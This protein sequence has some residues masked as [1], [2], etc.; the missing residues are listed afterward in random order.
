MNEF[1]VNIEE[2]TA[3]NITVA[4]LKHL[5]DQ[6]PPQERESQFQQAC[7]EIFHFIMKPQEWEE[8]YDDDFV[9]YGD[10]ERDVPVHEF[11]GAGEYKNRQAMVKVNE[12]G[13]YVEMYL[14]DKFKERRNLYKHSEQYA[15][16]CAENWVMGVI[17]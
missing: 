4:Y 16:D 2:D 6:Y 8:R 12:L 14:D 17:N 11:Y 3:Q 10:G 9:K 5:A 15:E 1:N 13:F 7:K